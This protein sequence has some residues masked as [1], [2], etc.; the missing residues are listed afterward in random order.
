MGG[1][2]CLCAD[3]TGHR[4]V[5]RVTLRLHPGVA[6]GTVQ[7]STQSQNTRGPIFRRFHGMP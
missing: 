2:A 1:A 5:H 3:R 7:Y 6:L 4:L